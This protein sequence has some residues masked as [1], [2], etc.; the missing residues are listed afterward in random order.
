MEE[1]NGKLATA[2]IN[3]T[4]E[5]GY[6]FPI[7]KVSH[8][9]TD[10]LI[11]RIN[12]CIENNLRY[13]IDLFNL[14][15]M[16]KMSNYDFGRIIYLIKLTLDDINYQYIDNLKRVS[17]DI[18][19]RKK[20][21]VF[22]FEEHLECL[23]LSMISNNRW[24]NLN[25]EKNSKRIKDIFCNYDR[26]LLKCLNKDKTIS[27]LRKIQCTDISIEKQIDSI[28][29]NIEI[30]EKIESEYGS[31]DNYITKV[32]PIKIKNSFYEGKYKLKQIGYAVTSD[33][34]NKVG[35][36]IGKSSNQLSILF[37]ATR[38]AIIE[39][40]LVTSKQQLM[41]I[42]RLANLNNMFEVEVQWIIN[43][44]YEQIC[45]KSNEDASVCIKCR[46]NCLC[47]RFIQKVS[48]KI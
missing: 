25:I 38:L 45:A 31:L 32:S 4:R 8:I 15:A 28:P 46:L 5:L 16:Q 3:Y 10:V 22:S 1:V 36:D 2:L 34:L 29:C 41:I 12:H 37:G 21:K 6:K 11:E 43:Q 47:K 13:D 26:K 23:I 39:N 33:Y 9:D 24:G 20:G 17:S 7:S 40:D 27:D 19:S 44:F 30:F 48:K 35:I 42:K 18:V 14:S